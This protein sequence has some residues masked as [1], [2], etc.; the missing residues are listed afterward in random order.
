[1]PDLGP[2]LALALL[3]AYHGLNPA[4]GWL[5]AVARGL[6]AGSRRAVLEALLPIALGH[7]AAVGLAVALAV[8]AQLVARSDQVR[9]IAAVTLILFGLY[10]LRRWRVHPRRIGLQVGSGELVL[11]S[12]LMSSAHGAGLMLLPIVFGL[13]SDEAAASTLVHGPIAV[14]PRATTL[15]ADA[16]AVLVHTLAM[17]LAMGFT[18]VLVYEKLGLA[19]LRRA[20]FNFDRL[21]ALAIVAAGLLTLFT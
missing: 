14:A 21:W 19:V 11:W 18:A 20:W 9:P 2:W 12:F 4:M 10:R 1:M 16:A 5:L 17:L 13:A 7:E 3:G 15:V 8:G 6:Q